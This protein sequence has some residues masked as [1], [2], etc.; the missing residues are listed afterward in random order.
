MSYTVDDPAELRL[1]R[2]LEATFRLRGKYSK[3]RKVIL[4]ELNELRGYV[5]GK[6]YPN[7][8]E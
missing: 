6:N 7:K 2:E 4:R 5:E 1:L 3:R 8:K